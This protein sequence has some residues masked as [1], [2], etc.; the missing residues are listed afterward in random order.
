MKIETIRLK[1]FKRFTDLTIDNI[2]D[3]TKLI[4][5]AGPN[6][7]GKSSLFDAITIR[8]HL[9][10]GVSHYGWQ[11]DYHPKQDGLG[12]EQNKDMINITFHQPPA[13]MPIE[14]NPN[15]HIRTAY[16]NDPDVKFG[17]FDMSELDHDYTKVKRLAD[18]DRNVSANYRK[19][20]ARNLQD[21]YENEDENTKIGDFRNRNLNEISAS[22]QNLFGEVL[23]NSLG[24][25][26]MNGTFRFDKGNCKGFAYK[27]LSSGEKAAFDLMLDLI[28]KR[29]DHADS[30]F[31]ID[32]PEAHMNTKLQGKL[33]AELYNLIPDNSQLWVATHSIGMMRAAR[34][35]EVA[36]PGSVAFI[37]MGDKDFD[38][39][40]VLTPVVPN[41]A[42]WQKTLNVALDDLS[43]LMAPSHVVI[44]EGR[45]YGT[46][47]RADGAAVDA[48]CYDRIFGEEYPEVRFL[49][50][51]NCHDVE[52]DKI[53]LMEAIKS[54]VAGAEITRIIDR[55][56]RNADEVADLE[57]QGIRVLS[58]RHLESYL[59]DD[60]VIEAL[61]NDEGKPEELENILKDKNVAMQ[62]LADRNRPADD[63]KAASNQIHQAI[64]RRLAITG[65]G[66]TAQ[67]FMC[68]KLA[69]LVRS[70]M[71]IYKQLRVDIFGAA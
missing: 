62:A 53:A 21:L 9:N 64:K 15:V 14:A 70:S 35:L 19:L 18:N 12:K 37:D 54:L 7:C 10:W 23:L 1:R 41:R 57:E 28:I 36:A 65:G 48:K 55:D 33:L 44:C 31:C 38:Q 59:F 2:P 42:F 8:C 40:Q 32:E 34:D 29:D 22:M 13:M 69:P 50:G 6:G 27:N 71:A 11:E 56:D 24:N 66:N 60:E 68:F 63:V 4:V 3:T 51:G 61:C 47:G 45:P 43:E 52:S 25:P 5:L 16:R 46:P 30:L 39:P 58:K 17:S 20:V 26:L 67:A 49:S